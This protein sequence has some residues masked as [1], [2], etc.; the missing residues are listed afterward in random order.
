[1]VS[2]LNHR[3]CSR[4]EKISTNVLPG[5]PVGTGGI[6]AWTT[7]EAT[8]FSPWFAVVLVRGSMPRTSGDPKGRPLTNPVI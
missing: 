5:L 8:G 6:A 7:A 4:R 1:M 3:A 2:G